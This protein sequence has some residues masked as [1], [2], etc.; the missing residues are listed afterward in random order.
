M[1]YLMLKPLMRLAIW[2]YF[3]K[4]RREGLQHIDNGR[5]SLILANHTASFMD[6]MITAVHVKRRIWFFTRGDVFRYRWIATML[7]S[8][9]MLPVYRM[10]DGKE[11][12]QENESSNEEALRILARGGAVLIFAEGESS[13]EKIFKPLKKGPFR[14]AVRASETPAEKPFLVPLGINYVHPA[15]PF[16][17]AWLVAGEPYQ[18]DAGQDVPATRIATEAMRYTAAMLE[19]RCW[20]V[21]HPAFR[22]LAQFLLEE[23]RLLE[24]QPQF[25]QTWLLTQALNGLDYQTAAALY[26]DWQEFNIWQ[27]HKV[28]PKN[29]FA[30]D[31]KLLDYIITI[32]GLP[33]ALTGLVLHVPPVNTAWQF[34]RKRVKEP[35][36]TAPVFLCLA[37]IFM[38]IWYGA[39]GSWLFLNSHPLWMK[40]CGILLPA[41]GI[42]YLK[43]WL[44]AMR[45]ATGPLTR[46]WY[47]KTNSSADLVFSLANVLLNFGHAAANW[48][49]AEGERGHV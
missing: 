39:V 28:R 15:A 49:P 47:R 4:V 7:R 11:R 19:R 3:G 37:V 2:L 14:L 5:P 18:I 41:G 33:L 31:P 44:P 8:L 34:T 40:I 27:R 25:R 38:L 45:R 20:H 6:A 10:R 42:F 29:L 30:P 35:D 12:L 17:D 26:T 13:V 21:A 48:E 9:G 32:L 22:P 43:A 23:I 24:P 36:F 1:L 16:G 46:R